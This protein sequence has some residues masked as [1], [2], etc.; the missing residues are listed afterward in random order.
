[1]TG[2]TEVRTQEEMDALLSRLAGFHDSMAKELHLVNR[3]WIDEDRSMTM[4]HRFDARLLI[5]SQW[6]VPGV[7]LLF[8][9]I[10][11]LE[12]GDA[13]E[14]WGAHG[15]VVRKTAPVETVRIVMSF[16]N[17]LKIT[18]ERAFFVERPGWTGL[19]A[20]LGSEVPRPECVSAT[21]VGGT[22]RQCSS[23]AD[24][25]EASPAETYVVCPSC[26]ELTELVASAAQPGA[27]AEDR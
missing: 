24:A 23:C 6:E 19:K 10:S 5:Q 7:E 11:R 22:W 3:G 14:Y 15:S 27:A 21:A 20:R 1:M 8:I 12:A 4:T 26:K 2:Y 13:G 18:A 25:F 16:D 17:A 9:G